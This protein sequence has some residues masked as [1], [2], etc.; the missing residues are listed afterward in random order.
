MM[1]AALAWSAL[2]STGL[3]ARNL[4]TLAKACA[5]QTTR[6]QLISLH[7]IITQAA[8]AKIDHFRRRMAEFEG[9]V[10]THERA[11]GRFEGNEASWAEMA[12]RRQRDSL[13]GARVNLI[14]AESQRAAAEAEISAGFGALERHVSVTG[15]GHIVSL[16]AWLDVL[17]PQRQSDSST[18]I[19]A[20]KAVLGLGKHS[21]GIAEDLLGMWIGRLAVPTRYADW[22]QEQQHIYHGILEWLYVT[23]NQVFHRGKFSNPADVLTAHAARGIVDLVLEFLGNWRAVENSG[24]V[25]GSEIVQIYKLLADRK[26]DLD[27]RL[28]SAASCHPLDVAQISA[29]NGDWWNRA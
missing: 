6:Q 8:N 26:D 25:S 4:E 10:R 17:L 24:N 23:R 7:W 3:K 27:R 21:G 14:H 16:N 12:L 9:K 13:K 2:E 29:P 11:V 22:L 18:L 20:R 5:L 1:S 28:R 19:A 15:S